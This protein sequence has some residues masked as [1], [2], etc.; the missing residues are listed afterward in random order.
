MIEELI[1]NFITAKNALN[2]FD[3]GFIY[4]LKTSTY[5]SIRISEYKN[6]YVAYKHAKRFNGDNGNCT[7]YTNNINSPNDNLNEN[8]VYYIENK[9]D[10]EEYIELSYI[11]Q[12][13]S[14]IKPKLLL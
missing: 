11:G 1:E 3:D 4:L 14:K 10:I 5:R 2:T 9:E 7:I 6:W 8:H 13:K 12:S